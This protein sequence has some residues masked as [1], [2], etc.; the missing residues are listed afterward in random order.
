M[1]DQGLL[2]IDAQVSTDR[3]AGLFVGMNMTPDGHLVMSTDH[4]WLVSL[5]RDFSSYEAVLLPGATEQA[6][7]HCARME[8]ERG[9]TAYGWVRTSLCC[10][11]AGGIYVNSVDHLHKVVWTGEAFSQDPADGAWSAAYRNGTGLGS[12]TT[13]SLMGFGPDEDRFVVIGDGDEVVNIT[14]F[15]RDAVPDDWEQ[16]PG[17]PSRR[18]AGIGPAHMGDPARPAIQT[19]QSITVAGYGAM[20][21]NNEPASCP[22]YLPPQGAR[23]LSFLLGHH[24]EYRPRGLHKYQWDPV[25]RQ[26]RE[27]WVNTEI[28]SPNSVPS[29]SLGAGLVYT[30]GTRGGRWTIE[31]LDWSTGEAVGHL[32]V[33]D[34]LYNTLGA[35]VILDEDGRIL[36]GTIFGKV[37][38]LV[39]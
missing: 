13:P 33:G 17:A 28:S 31:A 38:L 32:E 5:K 2:S 4:G 35:G 8:N 15:W 6:A 19:E 25:E 18:I 27:A 36:Y 30:C 34:S 12:G 24:A 26:L 23:M 20:T 37:R 29:V 11:E 16:I 3:L 9:N 14:L 1:G 10:D 39:D 7:G 21:V 22:E